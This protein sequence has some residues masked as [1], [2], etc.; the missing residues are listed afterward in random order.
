MGIDLI[1]RDWNRRLGRGAWGE[2]LV[3]M[4][5]SGDVTRQQRGAGRIEE[6]ED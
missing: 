6:G 5:N 2:P 4:Q 3:A 1:L